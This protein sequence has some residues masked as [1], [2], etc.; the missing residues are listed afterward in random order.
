MPTFGPKGHEVDLRDIKN[1]EGQSAYDRW[2]ELHS[3]MEVGGKTLHESMGELFAS[4]TYKKYRALLGT[5]DPTYK[6]SL[7]TDLVRKR[8]D[9]Y[10]KITYQ[11]LIKEFP[12]LGKAMQQF[13]V[14]QKLTSVRG[15]GT[16]PNIQQL[17]ELAGQE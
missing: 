2:L 6:V 1:A 7:A 9:M 16:S 14:G 10:E 17:R 11:Q 5:G 13:K 15:S 12:D 4:D 3:K 8:F